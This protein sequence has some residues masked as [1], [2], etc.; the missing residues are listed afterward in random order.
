MNV[1]DHH[2]DWYALVQQSVHLITMSLFFVGDHH[3]MVPSPPQTSP[4]TPRKK[5]TTGTPIPTTITLPVDSGEPFVDGISAGGTDLDELPDKAVVRFLLKGADA[6]V[7]RR[8]LAVDFC[9]ALAA[10]GWY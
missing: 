2:V 10:L 4:A 5:A 1:G 7:L 6:L 3:V 9:L 8:V